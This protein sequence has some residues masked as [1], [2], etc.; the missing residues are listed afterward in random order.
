VSRIHVPDH[1]H[2]SVAE[3]GGAVLLN[4]KSGQ[5]FAMNLTAE[6]LW[7]EW[8]RT[9]DFEAGI[10]R[11]AAG[12]PRLSD[13]R[14]R[15]DARQLA[16]ALATRGL[17]ELEGKSR[18]GASA[19]PAAPPVGEPVVVDSPPPGKSGRSSGVLAF[20][21]ALLLLRL[22]LGRT[23]RVV[24]WAQERRCGQVAT[25]AQVEAAIVA[26]ERAARRYPG[27]AACLELS[28]AVVMAMI[29]VRRRVDWVIGVADD[30]YRFHAWVEIEGTPVI[31]AYETGFGE[32]RRV[33]TI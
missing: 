18:P 12:N 15:G 5:W 9:G 32:F 29:L 24:R 23:V 26:A 13:E 8:C 11:V 19:R 3:H 16:D 33:L 14:I 1:V 25:T 28:L 6:N 17:V 20:W 7:Q 2:H 31:A 30:P 4:L 22:P 27:R 21:F 10:H